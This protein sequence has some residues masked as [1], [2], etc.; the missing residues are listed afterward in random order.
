MP[1][2]NL[3]FYKEDI[4]YD[5]SVTKQEEDDIIQYI[6]K[7]KENE[8]KKIFETDIRVPVFVN[9]SDIRNNIIN[10]YTFKSNSDVLEIG[11][12]F[13][14]ITGELC[15]KCKS[16][17][18]IEF[19]KI[20]AEAICKRHEDKENLEV[21]CGKLEDISFDK[22]YDYITIF[23]I[24]EYA[25]I[26]FGSLNKLIEYAKSLLNEGGIILIAI[27]NK[28]GVKY[29][30]GA[31]NGV[32]DMPYSN[33]TGN[34]SNGYRTYG[35][36]ELE[37]IFKN[38]KFSNYKFYYPLPDYKLTNVIYSDDYLPDENDSKVMYNIYYHENENILFSELNLIKELIR[39][40]EFESFSNS[41]LIEVNSDNSN[42][43]VFIGFNNIRKDEYR[44]IT[45]LTKED[46]VKIVFNDKSINHLTNIARNIS[47]LK[48][49]GFNTIEIFREDNIKSNFINSPTFDKQLIKILNKEGRNNFLSAIDSWYKYVKSKFIEINKDNNIF[50]KF[51]IKVPEQLLNDMTIIKEGYIDLI[52]QNVFVDNEEYIIFD[53]EWY[54][55]NIPLEFILYR[56]IYNL[57]FHNKSIEKVIT[58]VEVYEYYDILKYIEVF[59]SLERKWQINLS[60]NNIIK[61]YSSTYKR[62]SS[63]KEMNLDFKKILLEKEE[64][65]DEIAIKNKELEVENKNLNDKLNFMLNSRTWKYTKIF[66]K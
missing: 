43:N 2:L 62:I 37:N 5:T 66:R 65:I 10:W 49:L 27:D 48:E 25:D 56:S 18:S 1:K 33:L 55:E 59:E 63:L 28:F 14:S 51:N 23:G 45:K 34:Y 19:I 15:K 60:N 3:E 57:F 12:N 61:F 58:K 8:Y 6:N 50:E 13:G 17:T 20:R 38:N 32:N 31:T 22:K 41:F 39:N 54:E 21:I 11:G 4:E 40:R 44:L 42:N 36:H 9:L 35:K 53:Q 47:K 7:Y 26:V 29:L 30:A 24:A 64:V 46:A 16:V 52:F